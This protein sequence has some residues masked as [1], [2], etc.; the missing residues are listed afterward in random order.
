MIK[1][2]AGSLDANGLL[3]SPPYLCFFPPLPQP[4]QNL[5]RKDYRMQQKTMGSGRKAEC[6][7]ASSGVEGLPHP[8]KH[9][10]APGTWA[11][12]SVVLKRLCVKNKRGPQDQKIQRHLSNA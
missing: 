2:N 12:E 7:T 4:R 11:S 5:I 3:D 1:E 8:K 9:L 6:S 10:K